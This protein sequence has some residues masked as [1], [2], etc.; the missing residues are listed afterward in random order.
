MGWLFEYWHSKLANSPGNLFYNV[1]MSI[2]V[3]LVLDA[4]QRSA[5]AVTRSLGRMP[6]V[7]VITADSSSLALAGTSKFSDLYLESPSSRNR[8][9]EFIRWVQRV[10]VE[11]RVSLLLPVTEITS[12]LLLLN[13]EKLGEVKL[14]FPDHDTLMALADKGNLVRTAEEASIPVP[15]SVHYLS[16]ADIDFANITYPC[17]VKPCLSHIFN[18]AEWVSTSVQVV[19]SEGELKGV[20]NNA[21]H[22]QSHPFMIQE[23]IPGHGAGVFCFFLEGKA[24]AIFAHR[25]LREKPPGGGVSVLSESVDVDKTLLNYAELL[26]EKV[27]WRGV[28]MVEFRMD[29]NGT[30]WLME[31][32]TRFWGS[33]QLAI[34]SGVDFPVWVCAAELGKSLPS[35]HNY[36]RGQRLRW[37]LGDLDRLYL[38]FKSSKYRFVD[39][40]N[41]LF[42][43][44]FTNPFKGRFE[45]NR[46]DDL[47][48]GWFELKKYIK[49]ILT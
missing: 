20:V 48:P 3:I 35:E 27:A 23:F 8:P 44:V 21:P 30:P 17:V 41:A 49:E 31:V 29:P 40:L 9:S 34:D 15:K 7:K 1:H 37:F 4:S 10:I 32:N 2:D 45:V 36:R 13:R 5:L 28:A 19:K 39:K 11:H 24:K 38:I 47:R 14:P 16:S 43:F 26:L 12:Q 25:R 46:W 33:L 22:L 42:T 18:G 6:E